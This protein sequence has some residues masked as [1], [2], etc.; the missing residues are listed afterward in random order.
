[1]VTP[2]TSTSRT[3]RR[4]SSCSGLS[5]RRPSSIA[6]STSE[7]SS[8][9]RVQR[10]GRSTSTF[11]RLLIRAVVVWFPDTSITWQMSSNSS[12]ESGS[13]AASA[14]TSTEIRS[15]RGSARRLAATSRN[16]ACI[17]RTAIELASAG[18]SVAI[19]ASDQA[20]KRR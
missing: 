5:K 3:A 10:P 17:S 8:R 20:L 1:M 18:A 14:C 12:S 19:T 11:S 6:A 2:R 13:P 4:Q 7:R 15:P 9:S 16:S